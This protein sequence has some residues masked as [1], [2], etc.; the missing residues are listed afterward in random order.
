[1]T[2]K[3]RYSIV[4]GSSETLRET[5]FNFSEYRKN[6]VSHKKI[7]DQS[8]LEW[9][10]GFSEGDGS[11][12][13]SG[14]RLF[15]IINQKEEKILHLV[16]SNLGFGKVSCYNNFYRY[17]V[18]DKK[19]IDRL[20]VLFNGNLVLQKTNNR[21]SSWLHT[22]NSYS[23][24]GVIEQLNR[25]LNQE[26]FTFLKNSAWLS[27]FIDSEGCFNVLKQNDSRYSLGWR[28]RLRFILDQKDE[29]LI[30]EKLKQFLKSG[31]I[32]KRK[33][34]LGCKT[35]Y[36]FTSF[37]LLSHQ[38]L[39]EYLTRYPLRSK[40]KIDFVRWCRLKGYIE[41]RK[42]LPWQGKVLERITRL[43]KNSQSRKLIST[44][45]QF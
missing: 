23:K 22:R 3:R 20:L 29:R 12:I 17:I 37:S 9:F 27:G 34:N 21:F 44:P 31:T 42:T 39:V 2:L 4:R 40:K 13:V 19:N 26:P 6:L 35:M 5:T 43:I 28:V 1:M 15:F 32:S 25:S 16:R 36:R 7:I 8:F 11:F 24:D 41:T 30:F 10:V 18:A 14:S 33:T 45:E 38:I